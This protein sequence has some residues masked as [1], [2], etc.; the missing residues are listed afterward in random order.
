MTQ[1]KPLS[2]YGVRELARATGISPTTAVRVKRGDGDFDL[3]TIRAVLAAT[4]FCMCCQS[5]AKP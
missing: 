1:T 2:E 5:E 4:G 3:S